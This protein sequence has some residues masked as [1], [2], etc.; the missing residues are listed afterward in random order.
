MQV[1]K[2]AHV[3]F[4]IEQP[5]ILFLSPL[6]QSQAYN[7]SHSLSG[8]LIALM[9]TTGELHAVDVS[10]LHRVTMLHSALFSLSE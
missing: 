6:L 1:K 3:K 2:D 10:S 8:R 5:V 9:L 7:K 4:L